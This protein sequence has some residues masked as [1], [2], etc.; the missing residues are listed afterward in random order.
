MPTVGGQRGVLHRCAMRQRSAR[1]EGEVA[2]GDATA[3]ASDGNE[4][5]VV[6]IAQTPP[7][8]VRGL[9][10]RPGKCNIRNTR[11]L[12]RLTGV[13]L[14]VFAAL[15]LHVKIGLKLAWLSRCCACCT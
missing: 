6:R 14:R 4:Q 11:L 13:A 15:V 12:M 3:V 7:P 10:F 2:L 5:W 9:R 1:R 8:I